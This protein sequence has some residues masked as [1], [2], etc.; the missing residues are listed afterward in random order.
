MKEGNLVIVIDTSNY[1]SSYSERTPFK[2]E[3]YKIT[4]YPCYWVRSEASGKE[5]ELY[6][7]QILEG[8]D[9]SEI[10]NLIDM[11]KY[12]LPT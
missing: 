8:L 2:G 5:Y 1:K 7:N 6:K 12:G 11:S 10:K 4:D 9:I 3:L